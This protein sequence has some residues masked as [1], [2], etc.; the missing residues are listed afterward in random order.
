MAVETMIQLGWQWYSW[1]DVLLP[2][3]LLESLA[4][5]F[6]GSVKKCWFF[7]EIFTPAHMEWWPKFFRMGTKWLPNFE[8]NGDLQQ[9][10]WGPNGDK[11]WT[12]KAYIWQ[13]DQNE[14]VHW[15]KRM[16]FGCSLERTQNEK[17][18]YVGKIPKLGGGSRPNPLLDVYLPSYFWHAKIILRC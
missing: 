8:W 15:N 2:Q 12:W 5:P 7:R 18:D 10:K 9:Q 4:G 16:E 11:M 1:G 14:L 13:I 17:R 6:S 3:I